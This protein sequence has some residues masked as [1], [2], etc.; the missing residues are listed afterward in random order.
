VRERHE[1]FLP[2][3]LPLPDRRFHHR[4]AA[5]V[6]P[7]PFSAGRKSAAPCGAAS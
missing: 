5:G 3:V 2:G 6:V 7:L 4:D 1:D